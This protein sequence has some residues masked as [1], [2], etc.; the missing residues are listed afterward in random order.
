MA[1]KFLVA[2]LLGLQLLCLADT[3]VPAA[4]IQA[5]EAKRWDDAIAVYR[6]AIAQDIR[7]PDLWLR[8]ADIE[9]VRG[10]P[11][12][13]AAA[14]HQAAELQPDNAALRF[15]EAK[16]FSAAKKPEQA[17]AAVIQ[18]LA[19]SPYDVE[20][21]QARAQYSAWLGKTAAA[22][23]CYKQILAIDPDNDAALLERGRTR[24]MMGKLDAAAGDFKKYT[25]RHPDDANVLFEQIKI[26]TWRGNFAKA[27]E[28]LE[29]HQ[30]KLG[31]TKDNQLQEARVLAEAGRAQAA[32][33]LLDPLLREYPDD[34]DCHIADTL[35]LRYGRQPKAAIESI[36]VLERI[37]PTAT[38]AMTDEMRRFVTTD[39]R[40][41]LTLGAQFYHESD[42]LKILRYYALERYQLNPT[43]RLLA[44]QEALNLFA[45]RGSGL[46]K[47]DGGNETLYTQGWLGFEHR[48]SPEWD[49]ELHL[50]IAEGAHEH[51]TAT[52]QLRLGYQPLDELG[53][54]L[55]SGYNIFAIS[56]RAVSLN[57]RRQTN[58]LRT[59]WTPDLNYTVET[60]LGY[61]YLT[62]G[63]RR[64]GFQLAPR[65]AI[66]RTQQFNLDIGPVLSW[67]GYSENP[68]H[69]YYSPEFLQ[70]YTLNAYLLWKIR[71]EDTVSLTVG[72]GPYKDN[73]M[74]SFKLG[75]GATVEGCFGVY[76]GWMLIV[77]AGMLNNGTGAAGQFDAQSVEL[78]LTKRF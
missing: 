21:W 29:L 64:W 47:L 9:A 57:I 6:A 35:A 51:Q 56:P 70:Q 30:K 17:L 14:V 18:A 4:G 24:V 26:E 13:A 37:N 8:I 62:D 50:G 28:L 72:V 1:V 58:S 23:E 44:G 55:D 77:R 5:E 22:E 69:G 49:G 12:A 53:F 75:A 67:Q 54:R 42:S 65:R 31:A 3:G 7:R 40:H 71:G 73:T 11:E 25:G 59:I 76:Q 78:Q 48:F 16:T 38:A 27:L 74:S 2:S 20:Y 60:T 46:E 61:D 43:N 19:L 15:R 36:Q 33:K 32:R 68:G 34:Y 41:Q 66:M 10:N 52:Y 45:D 39:F 63:N